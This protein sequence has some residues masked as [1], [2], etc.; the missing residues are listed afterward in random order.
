M[1]LTYWS[2]FRG[3]YTFSKSLILQSFLFL[4]HNL[5]PWSDVWMFLCISL[6]NAPA[7]FS[8][9]LNLDWHGKVESWVPFKLWTVEYPT[10]NPSVCL[11]TTLPPQNIWINEKRSLISM[12]I[13]LIFNRCLKHLLLYKDGWAFICHWTKTCDTWY[14][15][16]AKCWIFEICPDITP[17]LWYSS[18]YILFLNP[19][20]HS[21]TF[22]VLWY[23][24]LI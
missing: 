9:F 15:E 19:Y 10:P 21:F 3:F 1:F 11:S 8:S 24:C 16:L 13:R 17:H 5:A 12:G 18:S 4:V 2:S 22:L 7:T 14:V 6:K 23:A 20:M